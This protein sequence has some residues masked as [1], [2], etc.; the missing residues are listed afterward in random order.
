MG[1]PLCQSE[2]HE[3]G[4]ADGGWPL[5]QQQDIGGQSCPHVV[6]HDL[7]EV[8]Q[9]VRVRWSMALDD[10]APPHGAASPARTAAGIELTRT[11]VSKANATLVP[12]PSAPVGAYQDPLQPVTEFAESAG[13]SAAFDLRV[14]S[15]QP[16]RGVLPW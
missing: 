2:W 11:E 13:S 9:L 12:S 5:E 16:E 7:A 4:T 6:E 1:T 15:I 10:Y 3:S 14:M 8:M